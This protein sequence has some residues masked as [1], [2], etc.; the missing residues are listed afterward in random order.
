MKQTPHDLPKLY[1]LVLV[2]KGNESMWMSPNFLHLNSEKTQVMV[3][4][5]DSFLPKNGMYEDSIHPS[6]HL[7]PLDPG[8]GRGGSSLSRD[9]Q[10]SLTQ[11]LLPV[12]HAWNSSHLS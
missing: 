3:I 4:G 8:P 7:H 2:M 11:G 12:G 1:Y 6:I 9:A 10:T 5:A